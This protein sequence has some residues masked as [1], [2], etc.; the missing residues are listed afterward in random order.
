MPSSCLTSLA[1]LHGKPPRSPLLLYELEL[2]LDVGL[3]AEEEQ[4]SV[5][6]RL[7]VVR[8][9]RNGIEDEPNGMPRRRIR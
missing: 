4:A 9:A 8:A 6:K 1:S 3:I 7:D 2:T 5:S